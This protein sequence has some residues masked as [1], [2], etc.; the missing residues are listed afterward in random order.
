MC[1]YVNTE[2]EGFMIYDGASHRGELLHLMGICHVL[3]PYTQCVKIAI[4]SIIQSKVP[5]GGG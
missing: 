4:V 1:V 3:N 5:S 2:G